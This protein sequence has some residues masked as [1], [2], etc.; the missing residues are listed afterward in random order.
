[1]LRKQIFKKRTRGN[2]L[3]DAK[4]VPDAPMILESW[5]GGRVLPPSA[6][7]DVRAF[8]AKMSHHKL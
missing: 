2:G 1:M 7:K 4:Q 8:L 6:G 5:G 3:M